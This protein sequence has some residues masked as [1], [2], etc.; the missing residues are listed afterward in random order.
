MKLRT[1]LLAGMVCALGALAADA[2]APAAPAPAALDP[3]AGYK[4]INNINLGESGGWDYLKA[5][6][7]TQRLYVSRATRVMV[8]DLTKDALAGE[9]SNTQGVHGIALVPKANV[10]FTSNGRDNSATVFDTTT[11]KETARIPVGQRPD[12]IIYDAFSNCV[13]TFNGGSKDATA[14][15]ADKQAVV[16]TVDL[17][18][19]PEEAVADGAGSI[20]VNLENTSEIVQFDAQKLTVT[21]RW[22]L[23]PGDS[24]SGLAMDVK[25]RR[26]FSA[27]DNGMLVVSDADA[28]KV[29][30]TPAIGNGPDGAAFDPAAGLA[31]VPCGG[32]GALIIVREDTPDKYSVAATIPTMKGARTISLDPVSH[33]LYLAGEQPGA[34]G[35]AG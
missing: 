19:K 24:P 27:C 11:L 26:L 5:D 32:D 29:V 30:A 20:F 21:K 18:G 12:S 3:A 10:G 13:F 35:H 2:P 14:I 34:P 22:S 31:F 17:G 23:A 33:L 9:I 28:G 4:V 6:N 8:V 25:N 7:G 15:D 16:G 1:C